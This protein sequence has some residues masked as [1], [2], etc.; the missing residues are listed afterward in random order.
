MDES[1]SYY[2]WQ[3]HLASDRH[4]VVTL[5]ASETFSLGN[6][7]RVFF[8]GLLRALHLGVGLDQWEVMAYRSSYL[9]E[10]D[11]EDWRDRWPMNWRVRMHLSAQVA[12]LPPFKHE[13]IGVDAVPEGIPELS[14]ETP[15]TPC[16]V[17][18]DFKVASH[19]DEARA[20]IVASKKIEAL[21]QSLGLPKPTFERIV[22]GPSLIQGQVTTG[23]ISA[24]ILAAGFEYG[25]E[26]ERICTDAGGI[27]NFEQRIAEWDELYHESGI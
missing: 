9:G 8:E 16:I 25:V 24:D 27:C 6:P 12:Q 15:P 22:L 18:A 3:P 1:Y 13:S 7:G 21:R 10:P 19:A 26:I 4:L 14:N 2:L 5:T 23:V 11:A 20:Q 17:C